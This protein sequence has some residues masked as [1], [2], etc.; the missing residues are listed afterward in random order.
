MLEKY[1]LKQ[2]WLFGS[3]AR[4][5]SDLSSDI[6]ILYVA[7]TD[8]TDLVISV[9]SEMKM[10]QKRV[11]LSHYTREG[12]AG[13]VTRGSLFAW[14]LRE[15]GKPLYEANSWLGDLFTTMPKYDNHIEDLK[16]LMQLVKETGESLDTSKSTVIFDAG[17][18]STVIRNTCIILTNYLGATDYSPYAPQKLACLEPSLKMPISSSE[19]V[20]LLKCRHISER[21]ASVEGMHIDL[22]AL[23]E[24]VRRIDHWQNGCFSFVQGHGVKYAS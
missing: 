20:H 9:V 10:P 5:E 16:V 22:F 12:I 8:C 6:D 15:E 14:H 11:D 21:G 23:R 1:A 24:Y 19:Y 3:Y 4:G 2:V 17:V 7:E 13:L 18:L